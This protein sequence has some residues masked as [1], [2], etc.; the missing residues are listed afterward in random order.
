MDFTIELETRPLSIASERPGHSGEQKV[1]RVSK[2]S[3]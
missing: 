3:L 1:A 2:R